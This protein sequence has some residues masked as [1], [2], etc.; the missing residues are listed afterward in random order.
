MILYPTVEEVTDLHFAV[1]AQSGGSAGVRD[2]GALQSAVAQPAATFGGRDLYPSLAEKAAALCYSLI[3]NH[4]FI[5]GNKRTAHA[6]T[7][8]LLMLNGHVLSASVD[9]QEEVLLQVASGNLDRASLTEWLRK[10]LATG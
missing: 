9:E 6:A 1:V 4:P 10:H 8:A 5:D 2:E 3:Q 7:L